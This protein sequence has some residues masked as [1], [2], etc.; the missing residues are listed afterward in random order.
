MADVAIK[1][2]APIKIDISFL[3]VLFLTSLFSVPL[4]DI[5]IL[6]LIFLL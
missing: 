5:I 4:L 2:A 1:N 6:L 3:L